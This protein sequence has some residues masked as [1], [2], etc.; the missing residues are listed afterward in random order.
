MGIRYKLVNYNVYCIKYILVPLTFET[1][2][3]SYTYFNADWLKCIH[4]VDENILTKM[5]WYMSLNK[6][7]TIYLCLPLSN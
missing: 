3:Y 7:H 5:L 6:W 2:S 1:L 4:A